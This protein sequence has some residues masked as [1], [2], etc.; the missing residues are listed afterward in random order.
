M[1]SA[2][3]TGSDSEESTTFIYLFLRSAQIRRD[4]YVLSDNVH[5][6]VQVR[7]LS[8]SGESFDWHRLLQGFSWYI[9]IN[10]RGNF[11]ILIVNYVTV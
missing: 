9:N 3:E 11:N 8:A 6:Q 10:V 5:D 4:I 2:A 1:W 7:T